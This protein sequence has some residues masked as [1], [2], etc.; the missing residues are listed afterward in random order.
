MDHRRHI[1]GK[2]DEIGKLQFDFLV[3]QGLKPHHRLLDYG[4]GSGR[5]AVH[6]VEYLDKGHYL[7]LD[8]DNSMIGFAVDVEC[9]HLMHKKPVFCS[10]YQA[11][12]IDD[13]ISQFD[14]AIAQSVFTHCNAANIGHIMGDMHILLHDDAIV[15]ATFFEG[16]MLL[17]PIT[18]DPG[19]RITHPNC[20]P[21]HQDINF[22]RT[23]PWSKLW[24][25]THLGHWDHPRAQQMLAFEKVVADVC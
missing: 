11:M 23:Q 9:A 12:C 1:G 13:Y 24:K 7:G 16:D 18:H 6:F 3:A 20:D 21:Y 22:Y 4:C 19:G 14:F 10:P 8:I 5:G 25:V 15:Y 17:D 2:W